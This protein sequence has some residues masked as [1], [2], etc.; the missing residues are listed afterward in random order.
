MM[1]RPLDPRPF[2]LVSRLPDALRKDARSD[3]ADLN[4]G[5]RVLDAFL[6]GPVCM[7]GGDLLMVD[8]PFGRILRL[9]RG[10]AW[11]VEFEYDGWPNGMKL[12]PGG[13]LLVADHKRGLLEIDPSG[14]SVRVLCDRW[15]EAPFHGLNDLTVASNG[16]IY[17]TDQGQSGLEAPYGRV[18]RRSAEGEL[19]LLMEGI[20]SPNGLVLNRAESVLFLAVTR[21]NA[22]WRLPLTPQGGVRKAGHFIQLSGG[23]GPDGLAR[24]PGT[25]ELL[26]VHAGLGVWHHSEAGLPEQLWADR[27]RTYPT[28]LTADPLEAGTYFVTESLA[29]EVLRIEVGD[30]G[31]GNLKGHV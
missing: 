1:F 18:F 11:S 27:N 12:L 26:T 3:W 20:P 21:A 2:S 9:G 8:I 24:L 6:E 17:F 25:D 7:P 16:D 10:G 19:T 31:G 30:T 4:L 23:V 29:A 5:G 22:V 14:K 15:A 28:N 13:S